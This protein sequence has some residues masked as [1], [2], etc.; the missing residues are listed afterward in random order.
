L[1]ESPAVRRILIATGLLFLAL[2]V[3][4]PLL[5]VFTQALEKGMAA[6]WAAIREPDA[7]AAVRLTLIAAGSPSP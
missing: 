2:F 1:K 7:L 4:L 3:V 6:Y 5:T